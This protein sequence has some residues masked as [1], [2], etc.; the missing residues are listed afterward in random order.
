MRIIRINKGK[1]VRL[2]LRLLCV[3]LMILMTVKLANWLS[4]PWSIISVILIASFLPAIWFAT[5]III[6]NEENKTIYDGIWTMGRKLKKSSNYTSLSEII[7][8]KVKTK[9]T[10][11]TL[12]NKENIVADHEFRAILKLENDEEYFLFSHPLKDRVDEKVTKIKKKLE[13]N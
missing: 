9:R 8:R 7:I 2:P 4:E 6:I 1:A 12:S 10:V 5:K 13:I 3:I 11:Y